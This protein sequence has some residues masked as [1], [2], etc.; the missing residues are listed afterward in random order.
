MSG[1]INVEVDSSPQV[2]LSAIMSEIREE[3][4]TITKKNN[5]ALEDWYNK[6]VRVRE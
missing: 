6:Q 3:Y 5:K 4:E 1:Q 2:D